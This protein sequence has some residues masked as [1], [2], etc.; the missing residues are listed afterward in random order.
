MI[1]DAIRLSIKFFKEIKGFSEDAQGKVKAPDAYKVSVMKNLE[2]LL[3]GGTSVKEIETLMNRYKTTHPSPKD[4]YSIDEILS[5]FKVKAEKQEIKRDPNNLLEHGKF[6]FH[7]AL[8]IVPP[9]P[10]IIQLP[11]GTFQSSYETE[12]FFLEIKECFT[13]SD[14][15][16][17]FYKVMEIDVDFKERDMGAFKY[18]LKSY[19]IDAVLYMIDEARAVSEDMGK[20]NPTSPFDIRDYAESAIAILEDRKNLAYM[21]GLDRVI[22]RNNE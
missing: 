4:V 14:L 9:P 5:Y 17:Y 22:P 12:E 6:Y 3:A 13:L 20:S 15:V 18:V 1:N 11:D 8:Q 19:D 16:D 7:P 2:Q 21:E 10:T